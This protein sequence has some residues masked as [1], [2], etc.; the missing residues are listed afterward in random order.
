MSSEHDNGTPLL[1]TEVSQK[2]EVNHC[3]T[4]WPREPTARSG[5]IARYVIGKGKAKVSEF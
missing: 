2:T 4:M 3:P 5:D 1:A